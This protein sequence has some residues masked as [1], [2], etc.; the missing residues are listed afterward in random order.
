MERRQAPEHPELH[1]LG[2]GQTVIR[3]K[4]ADKRGRVGVRNYKLGT[5]DKDEAARRL[6][7]FNREYDAMQTKLGKKNGHANSKS[8]PEQRAKWAKEARDKRAKKKGGK[9]PRVADRATAEAEHQA[10]GTALVLVPDHSTTQ[11][12]FYH[13][14]K[15]EAVNGK[16][17]SEAIKRINEHVGVLAANL[18]VA[19]RTLK[20]ITRMIAELELEQ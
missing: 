6:A 5:V 8:T 12:T 17:A 4:G 1:I 7:T 11:R 13:K 2:N 20:M 14:R 18:E 3:Y 16:A 15:Q 10:P 9:I 19:G